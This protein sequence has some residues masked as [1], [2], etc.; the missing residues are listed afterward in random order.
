MFEPLPA[1]IQFIKSGKLRALAVTTAHRAEALPDLPAMG[2]FV[3][4]YEASGWTGLCGPRDMP[5]NV[6][7]KLNMVI[8]AGLADPKMKARF[9]DLGATTLPGS[10]TD[11]GALIVAETEKWSKV[12]RAGNIKPA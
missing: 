2:E 1:S 4:G 8:N 10:A 12:I 7:E 6:V 3:P 9:S 11:F 5:I